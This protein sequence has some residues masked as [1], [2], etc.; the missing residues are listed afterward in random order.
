MFCE[1][2]SYSLGLLGN[3]LDGLYLEPYRP[4]C[5]T[6][7]RFNIVKINA[8]FTVTSLRCMLAKL[9]NYL[10][11]APLPLALNLESDSI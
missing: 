5:F 3:C 1:I 9:I 10:H 11:R 8:T 7:I 2:S 6:D 4:P